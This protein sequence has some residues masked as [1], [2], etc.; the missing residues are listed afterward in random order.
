MRGHIVKFVPTAVSVKLGRQ[1]L[2][3]KKNSPV[4]MFGAGV[5]TAV[6]STVFACKATLKFEELVTEAESDKN[7]MREMALKQPE[8]YSKKDLDRDMH[9]MRVQTAVK[10]SRLY[11]PA[12]GL[13][14]LSLGLL[15]GSHVTLTRRNAAITAAYAAL[16][17]GFREYRARV[18]NELGEDRDKEF[19][20]GSKIKEIVE[21]GEHGHEV[22]SVKHIAAHGYSIYA[23]PF[24]KDNKHWSPHHFD[25]RMFIQTQQTWA[26][27]RLNAYGFLLL[28]DVYQ[29]LGMDRTTPGSVVGWVKKKN[30]TGGDGYISFGLEDDTEGIH[31]FMV[32]DE[33]SI[34]L[35]F[36]VDGPV[37]ELI[38]KI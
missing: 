33:K 4:L 32:G 13:G 9:L 12:V 30:L 35:D 7:Q 31:S 36:N 24:D 38:D 21:E 1:I 6:A 37:Y 8:R 2:L 28:N 22:K 14:L 19:R 17:K 34:W 3:A 5:A 20:Y 29:S 11:A 15:T 23:R 10:V 18:V 26:N 25:N 16:D 27:D